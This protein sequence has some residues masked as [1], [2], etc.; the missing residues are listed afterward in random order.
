MRG[1]A[2]IGAIKALEEHNITITNISGT[3]AGAVVGALYA[4][5]Y[6][7]EEM[8]VFFKKIQ[9]FNIKNYALNKP[10][11]IDSEKYHSFFKSYFPEDNFNALKKKLVITTTNIL[12]GQSEI[13]E[14]GELIKPILA[15]AAFP[16]V[17]SPIHLNNKMYVDGGV[18]NNFPV[19]LLV[20]TCDKIIGIYVNHFDILK[21]NHFKHFHNIIDRAM[22]IRIVR[23]D[24]RKFSDCDLVIAPAAL[25]Q[26]GLFDKKNTDVIFKIGYD[27]M[28]HVL[29][30]IDSKSKKEL[31][32]Q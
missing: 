3:S 4:Y 28:I 21:V 10:G 16:G 14:S 30:T 20:E 31:L 24:M 9:L 23:D 11:F 13:F 6:S 8:L 25:S 2:H 5:G 29:E 7:W 22:N 12:E 15:S 18:L 32:V 26:Y 1:A 27:S 17:F 19:D